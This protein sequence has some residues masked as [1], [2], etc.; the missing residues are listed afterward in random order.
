MSLPPL[1]EPAAELTV[2]EVTPLQPPPD[3][4]RRRDGR[5]EAAEERQGAVRRRRRP[6]LAG[7]DVPGRGRRRHARHRRVRRGRRVQPAAPDHPRAVSDI[8]RS[9]AESARGLRQGDQPVRRRRPARGAAGLLQRH[10]D[11]RPVRPDRR[12]HRQLRHP[13]PGQRRVR[14]ARQAVRVG[15]DLPLRRPGLGVLGRARPV[16]PLPVPRAAAAGHGAVVR[17]GRRARRAV[18]VDRL[19]PGH[20]GDQAAHRHRRAA[21]RPADDLRRPGDDATARSRSARTPSARSA[22]RTRPSPS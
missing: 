14:A 9:K 17:R 2:D 7:A 4:P 19:D 13:L 21:G 1:V 11:L 18:R 12:R 6:R 3:H 20:R 5:A 10:G 22:A 16:L 15:L 8:G